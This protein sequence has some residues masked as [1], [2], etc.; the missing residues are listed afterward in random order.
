MP[1]DLTIFGAS[2]LLFIEGAL[3]ALVLAYLLYSQ[4]RISKI[5]W[6]ITTGLMLVVSF[7]GAQ[8]AGAVYSDPRPFVTGH[9]KPLISHARDNGFP[10]DHALLAAAIVA[11][12]LLVS[13]YWAVLFILI[14]VLVDWARVGAGIHHVID[15]LGSSLIVL[16]GLALALSSAGHIVR[17]L[18]PALTRSGMIA[19]NTDP[20]ATRTNA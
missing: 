10:S 4:P 7:I 14:S 15:V 19:P 6:A 12:V 17:Y 2:Y 5:R 1:T 11:A 8:I 18:L 9:F 3:A 16:I 13:R 20:G